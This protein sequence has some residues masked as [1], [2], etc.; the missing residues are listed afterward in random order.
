[1]AVTTRSVDAV[2][3]IPPRPLAA[4]RRLLRLRSDSAL[5]ERFAA[6]DEAAFATLYERHRASVLSVCI[7][8]LGSQHDAE[9]AAQEAFAALAVC[10]RGT[11]PRELRAWLARVAR[12][13]AIDVARRRK[14]T[15]QTDETIPEQG[16]TG[17]RMKAELESVL[18][19]IRELP[20]SQRTA[21]LMR[22]LGGH[23]YV[24]IATLLEVDEEAVRGLIARARVGLRR[25]REATEMPC[26]SARAA[27][28]A[29]PDGRRHNRI[30]RRHVR[31]CPSC[32]SY[33]QALRD[34]A[35]ALRG[36]LPAPAGGLAGGGALVGGLA[37]KTAVVGGT[38]T[39]VTAACAVSVCAVGGLVLLAPATAP[40]RVVHQ[41]RPHSAAERFGSGP[42]RVA[43]PTSGV[44]ATETFGA[45][46]RASATALLSA[47]SSTPSSA[48]ASS[49][50]V[51]S[52]STSSSQRSTAQSTTTRGESRAPVS[53]PGDGGSKSGSGRPSGSTPAGTS[54]HSEG[55][56]ASGA[57]SLQGGQPPN[58]QT[59]GSQSTSGGGDG[60]PNGGSVQP[61]DAET[62][63]SPQ[64]T[65]PPSS[66]QDH[67]GTDG[68]A[69]L[70]AT[71]A[72]GAD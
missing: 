33:Q 21:L 55:S 9:D 11:P 36:M 18:A 27:L 51:P 28:A 20:E 61:N 35:R 69:V 16:G 10:L 57:P 12:N 29:E 15:V 22:E 39:Q 7:G 64:S 53:S 3:P 31:G 40:H 50:V 38:L 8:V 56:A 32:R 71:T 47:G 54:G 6:G 68:T 43:A 30:V 59:G 4:P 63:T 41:G 72:S 42:T 45:G 67:S 26:A 34:D 66:S 5:S 65:L 52:G 70:T 49:S 46:S 23:S 1:M 14:S 2:T 62:P 25:H 37:A 58:G 13:A 17:N 24:E 44:I 60:A 48:G 19:G